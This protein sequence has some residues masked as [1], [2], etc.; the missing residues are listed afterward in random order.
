VSC[1]GRIAV[2]LVY[3]AVFCFVGVLCVAVAVFAVVLVMAGE[4]P[5]KGKLTPQ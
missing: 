5:G 2:A 4:Q 3:S 1:F